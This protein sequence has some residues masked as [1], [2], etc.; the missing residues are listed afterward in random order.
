[1]EPSRPN[2]GIHT[3]PLSSFS[4]LPSRLTKA[5][6]RANSYLWAPSL[7]AKWAASF[8]NSSVLFRGVFSQWSNH[9]K[10]WKCHQKSWHHS[11]CFLQC[12]GIQLMMGRIEKNKD[13]IGNDLQVSVFLT[14]PLIK[15][16]W[17]L[18]ML[19]TF[20][21]VAGDRE[22]IRHAWLG[23]H[24]HLLVTG[25]W[26]KVLDI[27]ELYFWI[28]RHPLVSVKNT[29]YLGGCPHSRRIEPRLALSWPL[30]F[31]HKAWLIVDT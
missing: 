5:R 29:V 17:G 15:N 9:L 31:L 13:V 16:K 4:F 24:P 30:Q 12:S 22:K 11:H 8:R 14:A 7:L 1:M 18:R 26:A 25:T 20:W 10:R 23:T 3:L 27:S 6:E 21:R 19:V 2:T 28:S